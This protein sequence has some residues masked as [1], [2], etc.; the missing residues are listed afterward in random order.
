[1]LSVPCQEC[2]CKY[3]TVFI[4]FDIA[5]DYF[6]IKYLNSIEYTFIDDNNMKYN[7]VQMSTI[8]NTCQEKQYVNGDFK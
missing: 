1:M 7:C 3:C 5:N 6:N 4:H 8:I 2:G